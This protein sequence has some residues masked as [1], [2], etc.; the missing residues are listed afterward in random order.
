M[1]YCPE[2]REERDIEIKEE[3]ELYPVKN[4][5][6]EVMAKITYCKHCGEQIWNE[7]LDEINLQQAYRQYRTL[8]QLLQP[9]EIKHIRERYNITQTTFAK[10]LGFGEK[11]IA[12]Y[13]TG[14]IQ[15]TAQNILMELAGF[16]DVFEHLL[17][18]SASII[19]KSDYDKAMEALEGLKPTVITGSK[20]F[21][22]QPNQYMY[23]FNCDNIY[24]GGLSN[25]RVS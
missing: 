23:K 14:S 6:I 8:H 21:S 4:E 7:E 15:D 12:R 10:I 18:R 19:S 9:E 25:V 16:P 3:K 1:K 22:Y 11:T 24:F 20:P 5:P 17:K 2:C 13:E